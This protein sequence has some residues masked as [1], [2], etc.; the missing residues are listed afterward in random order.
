MS[1][2]GGFIGGVIV[3]GFIGSAA[4]RS[5]RPHS[6]PLMGILNKFSY[7][8]RRAKA[9]KLGFGAEFDELWNM[10]YAGRPFGLQF[11]IEAPRTFY[12]ARSLHKERYANTR[13]TE[14]ERPTQQGN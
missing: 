12:D 2:L 6:D 1:T 9:F 5:S 4:S 7:E 8:R 13:T 3:G 14:N 10:T 11:G